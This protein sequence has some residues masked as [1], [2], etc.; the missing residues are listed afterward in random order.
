[1]KRWLTVLGVIAGLAAA[2]IVAWLLVGVMRGPEAG[3]MRLARQAA[4]ALD[5]V[6]VRG[7]VLT[8][9]RTSRGLV[10]SRAE[11]HRGDGRVHIRYLS[12]PAE[13]L[14]VFR[15]G[16]IVWAS[17]AGGVTRRAEV[18]DHGWRE[19][20]LERNWQF[21]VTGEETIAGRRATVVEGRGPG[22]RLVLAL[23]R[24]SGFPLALRR[25]D[26][27]GR[28]VS[29]T[30]WQSVDFDAQPP[31]R[32][33]APEAAEDGHPGHHRRPVELAAVPDAVQFEVYAPAWLPS[34]FAETG[35]FIHRGRRIVMVEARY[36]DGLK[37]LVVLQRAEGT[38][39][40]PSGPPPS[41]QP[42]D[43]RPEFGRGRTFDRDKLREHVRDRFRRLRGSGGDA[44]RR[45]IGDTIV[46]I[47]GPVDESDLRRMAD[48]MRPLE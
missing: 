14:E 12:G 9:T 40:A 46:V 35:W 44:V 47:M 10:R 21:R 20:L 39:I 36:S 24:A 1:M 29:A 17:G 43:G 8:E 42:P 28:T 18:E 37:P 13:G 6:A 25:I 22:G 27:E 7:T 3:A 23:D 5:T 31:E 38:A 26:G 2:G 33:Q 48:S 41:G 34:G 11:V 45:S 30:T 15:Q 19:R 4:E 16:R 32:V